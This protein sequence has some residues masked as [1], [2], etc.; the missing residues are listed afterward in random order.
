MTKH[1]LFLQLLD[2]EVN[3]L[4]LTINE[5][6]A[7]VMPNT[8]P[9]LTVRGPYDAPVPKKIIKF[10]Q[11]TL[12]YDVLKI[13]SIGR[14]SNEDEEVVYFK[15]DSPNLRSI[16]YKPTFTIGEYGYNPHISIYRGKDEKWADIL[17]NFFECENLELL[18]AEFRFVPYI[19]KQL[20][21]LQ[22]EM[23]A[24]NHISRLLGSGRV[25]DSFLSRLKA[26]REDYESRKSDGANGF[27]TLLL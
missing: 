20:P 19:T 27:Q 9:H 13:C 16:W 23:I 18:C 4:L 5:I 11:D 8:L 2:P 6:V 1:F 15:I 25:S 24:A 10:C 14:F 26:L 12:K 7:G 22:S 21:L 17:T 3:T